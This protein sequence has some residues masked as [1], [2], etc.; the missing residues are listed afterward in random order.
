VV[1][2]DDAGSVLIVEDNDSVRIVLEAALEER[3]EVQTA[4]NAVQARARIA[5]R[6]FDVIVTDHGMPGE[7]GADLL[8]HVAKTFP[9]TVGIL[10]TGGADTLRGAAR[11]SGRM[12]VLRKPVATDDLVA[13]VSNGVAMA[14]LARARLRAAQTPRT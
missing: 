12:L 4:E 7:S 6:T 13:W 3:F 2:V 9:C 1:I 5:A 10:I 14:R 8:A 11:D